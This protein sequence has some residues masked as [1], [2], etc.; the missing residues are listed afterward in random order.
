MHGVLVL[1]QAQLITTR[2]S[3]WVLQDLAVVPASPG[4]L[5]ACRDSA[6]AVLSI[7]CLGAGVV[8]TP[9]RVALCGVSPG[10]PTL[11]GT[12]SHTHK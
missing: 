11:G 5:W 2:G 6:E 12:S 3:P 1:T 8:A 7:P 4:G 9:E 10:S